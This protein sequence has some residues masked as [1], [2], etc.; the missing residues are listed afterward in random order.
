MHRCSNV[1]M[2]VDTS[3]LYA[4]ADADDV[5]HR[6]AQEFLLGHP[7]TILVMTNHVFGEL[8]TLVRKRAGGEISVKVGE[9]IQQSPRFSVVHLN[10]VDE[11][12]VWEIFSRYL[13]KE[14][15]WVDCG[16]FHLGQKMALWEVF[17]FDRHFAQM[18]LKVWPGEVD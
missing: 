14:W 3:A 9:R 8:M 15:S 13:D 18:G 17:A 11:K 16:L 6:D 7:R 2:L 10:P 4:L 5:K 12:E 1:R